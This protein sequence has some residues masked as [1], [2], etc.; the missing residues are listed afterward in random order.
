[1]GFRPARI[2]LLRPRSIPVAHNGKIQHG[3]L[4]DHHRSGSLQQQGTIVF[5]DY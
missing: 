5:P 3:R 2:Y 4:K 1:M